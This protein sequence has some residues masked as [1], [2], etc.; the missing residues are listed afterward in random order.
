M[1]KVCLRQRGFTFIEMLV[2]V[3]II[4][5]LTMVGIA[6]FRVANQKARDGR[7]QGDLEQIRAALEMYRTDLKVYPT[8]GN[9]SLLT[10][11]Y[12]GTIPADPTTG[13]LYRYTSATGAIYTLCAALELGGTDTC[14]GN[15]GTGITC[16]YKI[17][18]PL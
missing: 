7:R 15:C 13:R 17:S 10:P 2:V 12:I 16:N 4:A 8:T 14:S 5:V 6:N 11:S 9:L 3:T 1:K 18:N